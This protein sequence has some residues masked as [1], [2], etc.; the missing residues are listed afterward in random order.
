VVVVS[1]L[2][3]GTGVGRVVGREDKGK[4]WKASEKLALAVAFFCIFKAFL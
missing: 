2:L 4:R 1:R 3:P